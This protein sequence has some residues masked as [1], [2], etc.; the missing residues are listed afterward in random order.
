VALMAAVP[1]FDIKPG[2]RLVSLRDMGEENARAVAKLRGRFRVAEVNDDYPHLEVAN[3]RKEFIVRKGTFFTAGETKKVVAV[4]G[5]SFSIKRGECLGLVGESGSGKTTVSKLILRALTAS[6]GEV[7]M[8]SANGMVDVLG[9]R[10]PELHGFRRQVQMIFQDPFSS[11]NPRMTVRNILEEPFIVHGIGDPESHKK[12][13]IDL[14]TLVGLDP[15]FLNRYPHSFSGGQ[16]QRIGIARAL[17]L[18]PEIMICDEP[19]SALDVSVQAQILNLLNDLRSELGLTSLF[20]SHNLAVVNYVAD[21]IAVMCRGRLVELAPREKLF[22]RPVHPY[23]KAL[24]ASV[25]YP[26]LDRLLDFSQ[27]RYSGADD[28]GHWGKAFVAEER[29]SLTGIEIQDGHFVLANKNADK[30][31]LLQ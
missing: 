5:V 14:M 6:S 12:E 4:D 20:I 21:R 23:T 16:R 17:A 31:E 28:I 19:V 8:N 26:D 10:G 22:A 9:L 24:L 1:H 13:I 18:R 7:W 2:E 30:R 27:I 3:L 15:R 29:E 25:P 11:L